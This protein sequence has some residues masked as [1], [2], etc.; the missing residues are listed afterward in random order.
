MLFKPGETVGPKM[1]TMMHD[2]QTK[3]IIGDL[4]LWRNKWNRGQAGYGRAVCWILYLFYRR[5]S[6]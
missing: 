5:K 3:K 2:L 1:E 4:Q 6:N